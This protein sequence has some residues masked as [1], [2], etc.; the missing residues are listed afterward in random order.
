MPSFS[1]MDR[2]RLAPNRAVKKIKTYSVQRQDIYRKSFGSHNFTLTDTVV[3][4][5]GIPV[6]G[7][8]VKLFR[9]GDNSFIAQTT[10]DV[11]GTYAFTL[12][13]NAG[14][15]Y[16]VAYLTGAPDTFGTSAN[17]LTAM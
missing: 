14:N 11:L 3:D 12:P 13:D 17:N 15:F 16:A 2:T 4:I 6:V 7:A 5:A 10:T 9:T 8:I 1:R